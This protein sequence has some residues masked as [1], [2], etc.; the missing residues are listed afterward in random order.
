[1]LVLEFHG[2]GKVQSILAAEQVGFNQTFTS[3]K[4][5]GF[6]SLQSLSCPAASQIAF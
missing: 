4:E 2:F 1:M 5:E 3:T 6:H